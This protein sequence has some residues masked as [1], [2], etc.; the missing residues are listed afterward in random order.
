MVVVL[1]EV[2]QRRC[3]C[4]AYKGQVGIEPTQSHE[5]LYRQPHNNGSNSNSN[6]GSDSCSGL[7]ELVT[8][9]IR[10]SCCFCSRSCSCPLHFPILCSGQFL[11]K[12]LTDGEYILNISSKPSIS[13][14]KP[15]GPT[16]VTSC[17]SAGKS[18]TTDS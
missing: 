7:W 17:N 12:G 8:I 11:C 15:R 10:H 2:V 5:R 4:A 14:T 3:L 16:S 6:G 13:Y 9:H 18:G 1:E